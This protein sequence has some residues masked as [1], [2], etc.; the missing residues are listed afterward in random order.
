MV[1]DTFVKGSIMAVGQTEMSHAGIAP[2]T[3]MRHIARMTPDQQAALKSQRELQK[4][5]K[6]LRAHAAY[7][8]QEREAR[9][10]RAL[11]KAHYP[12]GHNRAG[13]FIKPSDG[14]QSA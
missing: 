14:R 8:E 13:Q 7:S 4:L 5:A 11:N 1:D 6:Q 12:K 3:E 9:R 2:R 10:Q